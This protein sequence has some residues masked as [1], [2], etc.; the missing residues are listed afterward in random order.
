MVNCDA[1]VGN[2]GIAATDE[3]SS[4]YFSSGAIR[5]KKKRTKRKKKALYAEPRT[6]ETILFR[7]LDLFAALN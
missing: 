5:E 2:R 3:K 4:R 7:C 6:A 1:A